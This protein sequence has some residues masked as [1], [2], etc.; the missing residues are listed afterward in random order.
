MSD[1]AWLDRIYC[2]YDGWKGWKGWEGGTGPE[3]LTERK[4][5]AIELAR[6]GIQPP[7]RILEIGFGNGDF[8]IFLKS[9]GF[10][11]HGVERRDV[12][13]A[14]LQEL[15]INAVSRPLDDLD[16]DQ[17][18]AVFA[19]DVLEHMT[20][21]EL[22]DTMAQIQRVLKSGGRLLARFPNGAS[23]FGRYSHNG[24]LTHLLALTA[25]SFAQV[26][27]LVG[28]RHDGTW[29]A[30]YL[31]LGQSG[32]KRIFKPML[33]ALRRASEAF[34]GYVHFGIRLPLDPQL[35]VRATKSAAENLS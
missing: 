34:I 17:F 32:L 13:N 10:D 1:G 7:A 24:D 6:S 23:P 5:F 27:S 28:L 31:W 26:C 30:A 12:H 3:R 33:V 16:P 20:K 4:L 18:D 8:L 11:C 25:N 15:G 14:R 9:Q 22:I 2:D 35:T 21:P 19:F 29:N